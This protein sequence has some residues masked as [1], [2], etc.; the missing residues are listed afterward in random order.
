MEPLSQVKNFKIFN[1]KNS[2]EQ[3]QEKIDQLYQGQDSQTNDS[4]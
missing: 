3:L 1:R 2:G 4:F